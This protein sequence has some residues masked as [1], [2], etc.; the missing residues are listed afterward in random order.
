MKTDTSV[1]LLLGAAALIASRG[2]PFRSRLVFFPG[3]GMDQTAA[4]ARLWIFLQ[5]LGALRV[6]DAVRRL[7]TDRE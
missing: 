3:S 4:R 5:A 2:W 7:V 1:E 6:A